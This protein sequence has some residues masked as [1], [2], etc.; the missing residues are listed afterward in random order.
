MTL[1]QVVQTRRAGSTRLTFLP[2][3]GADEKV[4]LLHAL[5]LSFSLLFFLL[6]LFSVSVSLPRF[7]Y[8]LP[9]SL[10]I[11]YNTEACSGF[12]SFG[13]G[14]KSFVR[15]RVLRLKSATTPTSDESPVDRNSLSSANDVASTSDMLSDE[16]KTSASVAT[17]I[18]VKE[19]ASGAVC[20]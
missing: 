4:S 15:R 16:N 14:F 8:P 2:R 11:I 19:A 7:S 5:A 17:S 20:V 6:L 13:T 10:P 12:H 3:N 18:V 9:A 1:S